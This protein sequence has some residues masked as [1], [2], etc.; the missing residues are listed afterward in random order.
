VVHIRERLVKGGFLLVQITKVDFDKGLYSIDVKKT[1]QNKE[2][3]ISIVFNCDW[4]FNNPT[5]NLNEFGKVA[6][7]HIP[8]KIESF[9]YDVKTNLQTLPLHIPDSDGRSIFKLCMDVFLKRTNAPV[10]VASMEHPGYPL[11][12]VT[13]DNSII[14][15]EIVADLVLSILESIQEGAVQVLEPKEQDL[16]EEEDLEEVDENVIIE[17]EEDEEL[18]GLMKKPVDRSIKPLEGEDIYD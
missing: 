7:F 13:F 4:Q 14:K 17:F 12:V 11:T 18:K 9:P 10:H 1:H 15:E 6:G 2:L 5:E 16:S 3:I 8:G